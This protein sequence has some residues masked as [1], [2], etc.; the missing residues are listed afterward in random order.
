[1]TASALCLL[2]GHLTQ[3]SSQALVVTSVREPPAAA[4]HQMSERCMLQHIL[5]VVLLH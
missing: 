5:S 1:M 3:P 4:C 2:P